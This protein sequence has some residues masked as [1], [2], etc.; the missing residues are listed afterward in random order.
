M[1]LDH[2]LV[3]GYV[4]YISPHIIII[5][6]YLTITA[7]KKILYCLIIQEEHISCLSRDFHLNTFEEGST[8]H[9]Q[10]SRSHRYDY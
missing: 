3:G 7:T 10:L 9:V 4:R 2:H 6:H 5:G 8:G 1:S